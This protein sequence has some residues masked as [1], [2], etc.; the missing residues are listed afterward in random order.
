MPESPDISPDGKEVAFSGLVGATGDIFIVNMETKQVRNVTNDKF[1]DYS[2]TWSPDG[3]Y[4]V[5]LARISGNDKLFKLDLASGQKTQLTF[6]TFDDLAP[7][8]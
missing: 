5:Y 7:S 4:L 3:K 1:G 8:F 2:P 6:G